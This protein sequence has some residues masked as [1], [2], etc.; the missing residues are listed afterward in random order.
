MN[1]ET[2]ELAVKNIILIHNTRQK[3][4]DTFWKT[5]IRDEVNNLPDGVSKRGATKE[6][7]ALIKSFENEILEDIKLDNEILEKFSNVIL[8]YYAMDTNV[9]IVKLFN[10]LSNIA[11]L[12]NIIPGVYF[13]WS[14]IEFVVVNVVYSI[15]NDIK[16]L[17]KH[18]KRFFENSREK[19]K[20]IENLE[21]SI[22]IANIFNNQALIYEL[23]MMINQ[24]NE[25][26]FITEEIIYKSCFFSLHQSLTEEFTKTTKAVDLANDL[27]NSFFNIGKKYKPSNNID[28]KDFF[29]Q[30]FQE[31]R[32]FYYYK[33]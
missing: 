30:G 24:I 7:N 11:K 33:S 17:K 28:R 1:K 13:S 20:T 8:D 31:P 32:S 6:L 10:P 5:T 2:I 22:D 27:L 26:N 19:N 9:D 23:K 12:T 16:F 4:L 21:K 14:N 3:E 15:F 29:E 18:K 25:E